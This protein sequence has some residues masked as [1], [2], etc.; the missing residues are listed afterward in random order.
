M[1]GN[2]M[3]W[4]YVLRGLI[5]LLFGIAAIVWPAVVLE[6]LVYFFGFFAIIVSAFALVAGAAAPELAGGARWS[7]IL[8]SIIGILIGIF[9]LVFPAQFAALIV[10]IIALWAIVTGIGDFVAAFAPAGMGTRLLLVLLGIVSVIFGGI[11]LFYPLLGAVT[12]IWVLGIYAVIF[13]ILGI[14]YGFTS[15]S[16]GTASPAV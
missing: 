7:V 5:A 8:L 10:I 16:G 13:G 9:S 2:N 4:Y 1:N 12:I 15:G 14:I 3:K 6:F 11:L